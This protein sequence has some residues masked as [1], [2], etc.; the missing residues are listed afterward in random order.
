MSHETVDRRTKY[1]IGLRTSSRQT[2]ELKWQLFDCIFQSFVKYAPEK[3]EYKFVIA[4]N[5]K[6]KYFGKLRITKEFCET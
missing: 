4:T 2:I 6:I 1:N 5:S 3:R